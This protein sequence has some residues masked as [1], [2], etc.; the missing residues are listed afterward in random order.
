MPIPRPLPVACPRS[1]TRKSIALGSATVC[2]IDCHRHR[3]QP[4]L[5]WSIPIFGTSSGTIPVLPEQS[6]RR[7]PR[8]RRPGE[9]EVALRPPASAFGGLEA[10]QRAMTTVVLAQLRREE[11]ALRRPRGTGRRGLLRG[12]QAQRRAVD[13]RIT[14][15][16]G[17]REGSRRRLLLPLRI[18]DLVDHVHLDHGRFGKPFGAHVEDEG[19]GARIG[20]SAHQGNGNGRSEA[21]RPWLWPGCRSE[22][23]DRGTHVKGRQGPMG[24]ESA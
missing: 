23:N 17:W 14:R 18:L 10:G 6:V 20:P 21:S 1:V 24:L 13:A 8:S 12:A 2:R 22:K 9:P 5:H 4:A 7:L 11:G 19:V 3:R 16:T 15:P